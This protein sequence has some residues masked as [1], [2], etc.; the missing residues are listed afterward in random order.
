M[1]G[2]FNYVN[3]HVYHY[4][5]NNPVK[6]TDPDGRDL[7]SWLYFFGRSSKGKNPSTILND[8]FPSSNPGMVAE[9]YSKA[10]QSGNPFTFEESLKQGFSAVHPDEAV[11]HRQGEG[12]EYNIKMMHKD[13]REAVYNKDGKLVMD[14]LNLGTQ[15]EGDFSDGASGTRKHVTSDV[16]PYFLLGNTKS[17]KRGIGGFFSRL[18]VSIFPPKIPDDYYKH[19]ENKGTVFP[20]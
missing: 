11:F 1:G 7:K 14:P 18:F 16:L 2:V 13:G 9:F 12:N 15:N 4:A 6:Y 17:D 10:D 3:L 20:E 19:W 5:G 8:M